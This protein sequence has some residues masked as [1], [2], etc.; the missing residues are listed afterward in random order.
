MSTSYELIWAYLHNELS[1][2]KRE[3]FEQQLLSDHKLIEELDACQ[4]LHSELQNNSAT[5]ENS[6]EDLEDR[7]LAEWEKA[8]PE[9]R[10][11]VPVR[12]TKILKFLP[13]L[14]AAAAAASLLILLHNPGPV[15]WSTIYGSA[16]QMRDQT[17]PASF[18]SP[19][20]LHSI[21]SELKDK[22]STRIE[23]LSEETPP[24]WNLTLHLQELASGQLMIELSGSCHDNPDVS[25]VW[26][27]TFQTL[28]NARQN[29]PMFGNRVAVDI[30][31]QNAP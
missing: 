9:Y 10:E 19:A 28:E 18:Y 31:K 29:L 2:Q 27:E 14:A 13:P 6:D 30:V 23:Q 25:G 24:K 5:A 21:S 11:P 3:Q 7:L 26:N 8:H 1:P 4:R 16:P 20:E 12:R 17:E 22:I 15:Q